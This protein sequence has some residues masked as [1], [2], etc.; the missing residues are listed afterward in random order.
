MR[1]L[2]EQECLF[3]KNTT[4]HLTEGPNP[5]SETTPPSLFLFTHILFGRPETSIRTWNA[6]GSQEEKTSDGFHRNREDSLAWTE[7]LPIWNHLHLRISKTGSK[8]CTHPAQKL[9]KKFKTIQHSFLLR[10]EIQ[11]H[12]EVCSLFLKDKTKKPLE[13]RGGR[14]SVLLRIKAGS[15]WAGES[16]PRTGTSYRCF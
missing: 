16:R 1:H 9:G 10:F 15:L 11:N 8:P 3:L 6:G 4:H 2:K 7:Q 5:F 12:L 13:I 14:G